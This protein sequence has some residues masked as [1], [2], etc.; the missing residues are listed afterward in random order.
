MGASH[1]VTPSLEATQPVAHSIGQIMRTPTMS[2][3]NNLRTGDATAP[4]HNTADDRQR[5][6]CSWSDAPV[7]RS[8]AD[9][10][11][12]MF[13]LRSAR[14]QRRSDALTREQMAYS[15]FAHPIVPATEDGSL[16]RFLGER[17]VV[18]PEV[19]PPAAVAQLPFRIGRHP[20]PA[21]AVH[22][23]ACVDGGRTLLWASSQPSFLV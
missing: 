5:H 18:R 22:A 9:T 12:I 1:H 21:E 3:W 7:G 16:I 2:V 4:L 19:R 6:I 8:N 20:E 15:K 14:R 10:A 23:A 11:P 17:G 13:A